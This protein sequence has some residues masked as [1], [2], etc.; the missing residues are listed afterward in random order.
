MINKEAILKCI[1]DPMDQYQQNM[2]EALGDWKELLDASEKLLAGKV[3]R[4][5]ELSPPFRPMVKMSPTSR[6]SRA[7][8]RS[9]PTTAAR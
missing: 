2:T 1:E 5:D 8:A 3:V 7:I 9:W 6:I 4:D